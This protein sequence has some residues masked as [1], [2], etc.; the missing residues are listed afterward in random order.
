MTKKVFR[1]GYDEM[2]DEVSRVSGLSCEMPTLAKQAFKDECDINT[3][4]RN[5]GLSYE[6]P[7][8]FRLPSYG[9]FTGVNTFEEAVNVIAAANEQFDLLPADVRARFANNPVDFV[10]FCSNADNAEELYNMGLADR[11]VDIAPVEDGPAPSSP[12]ASPTAEP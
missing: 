3:I 2:G 10:E 1:T 5:F 9:D 8:S 12:L 6:I 4:V 11:P 7:S